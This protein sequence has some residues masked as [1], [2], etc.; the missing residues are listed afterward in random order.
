[1]SWYVK[2]LT[3]LTRKMTDETQKELVS[4][5]KKLSP[6]ITL[7]ESISSQA[8]IALNELNRRYNEKFSDEAK[9]LVQKLLTK[10]NKYS[11]WQFTKSLKD[12]LGDKAKGFSLSGSAISPEKSEI[13]KALLFDNVNYIKSIQS[14]YFTDITGAVARSIENGESLKE[15]ISQ[16]KI[17]AKHVERRAELIAQDQ[18]RKAYNSINLRNFQDSGIKKFKWLH[19]G[20][21]REPRE[22]HKNVLDRQIFPLDEGAPNEY[23]KKPD[24]IYPGQLPYCHCVMAAV[25]DFED[26]NTIA[27]DEWKEQDHPR[28]QN[29]QFGKGGSNNNNK[30]DNTHK[31]ITELMG[32]EIEG[33]KGQEA[34]NVLLEKKSGHVKGAFERKDIGA[35]DLIWGDEN[36]GLCHIIKRREEQGINTKD[37]VSNLADVIEKGQLVRKNER[38][39]YEIF[40]NGKMA[41]IEPELTNG[42]LTFLLTA[43]KRRKA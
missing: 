1:M 25:L 19:S 11:N 33:V 10:T 35:I 38:G 5:Y 29:G 20:G 22:W 36:R 39:R 41:I 8:R 42:K 15:F 12:M 31:D 13:M 17:K 4:I 14:E 24:F 7:D 43:Y 40:H 21:S 16:F 9:E 3:K 18:T 27:K 2:E 34:I 28:K 26:N 6:Q 23:G 32:E 30:E 37:F